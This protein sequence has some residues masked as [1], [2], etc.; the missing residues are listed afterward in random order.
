MC[1]T[2]H[3]RLLAIANEEEKLRVRAKRAQEDR[4]D[5]PEEERTQFKEIDRVP[6]K[7]LIAFAY[8]SQ[9]AQMCPS[10]MFLLATWLV[11]MESQAPVE[12]IFNK[13]K[14]MKSALR[15]ALLQKYLEMSLYLLCNGPNSPAGKAAGL[16]TDWLIQRALQYWMAMSERRI[17]PE[18]RTEVRED[19]LS[20]VA[21]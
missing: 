19:I 7:K 20:C 21:P 11:D 13:L 8:A 16:T 5:V 12:A 17:Q 3:K 14:R 9:L 2:N 1:D 10:M 15:H 18:A 6:L 4:D